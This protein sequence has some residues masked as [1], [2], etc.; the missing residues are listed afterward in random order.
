MLARPPHLAAVNFLRV[1]SDR[2]TWFVTGAD[3][4]A[5]NNSQVATTWAVDPRSG[6]VRWVARGPL[7]ALAS[8]IQSSPDSRL[9][10]VGYSTG[11]ADVLDASTG[12]LV[13]RDTSS[14]SIAAGDLAFPP[15]DSPLV[16]VSLDGVFR[17]WATRGSEQL[18]LQAPADPAVDFTPDSRDV[19]LVGDRGEVVDRRTG[20]VVR[21]F[22]GF[23]SGSV[24]N[25]CNSACFAASPGL[26]WLT[27]LDP[28]SASPRIVEIAGR[29][30]RFVAAV[31]VPRLD[32]Q[33]VA[34]DGRIVVA[35]VDGSQLFARV[36]EPRSGRVREL[37]PAQSSAGCAASTPSFTPD[38]RLMAIVDSC[39]HLV[40]WDLR[41]GQVKRTI[42]LPDRASG[43]GA[44][45]S[46]DGRYALVTVLG[47]AFVRV[48][49]ATGKTV[50]VPGAEAEGNVIAV[51]P[52]G[53][54]Y[55]IGRQDGTVDVYDARSLRLV[56]RHTLV[57]PVEALAFSPDSLGL[58]VEDTSNIVRL[59]D[60]CAVCENPQRLA[61]L[62][63]KQSVRS[64]TPGERATFNV[65]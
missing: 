13:V 1:S 44:R 39:I 41:S 22:A 38:G 47:G 10:A 36:I 64:L 63:V 27:Y 65:R 58:A 42:V 54:F 37:S 31:T 60:T 9:V 3:I 21:R 34:R 30:G 33:G 61:Q 11:A 49:L 59:W 28:R 55:A 7:G 45:L 23:P 52:D 5:N 43:S 18:R 62:A 15:G 12:R 17:T 56:R 14:S 53:R 19:V 50:E 35:Y 32:A 2:R 16:T 48:D 25:T 26:G 57:N 46:P 24:F 4:N 51:S 29:S 40:V 8:P 20:Q 6:H